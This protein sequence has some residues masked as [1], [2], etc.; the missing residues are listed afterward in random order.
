MQTGGKAIMTFVLVLFATGIFLALESFKVGHVRMVFCDIGQGDGFFITSSKGH[1]IVF[2]GGPGG[3]ITDC[4]SRFLPIWNRKIDVMVPTHPQADH[5]TGQIDVFSKYKVD[6]VVWTGV[7]NETDFFAQ[8]HKDLVDEKSELFNLKRG[9]KIILDDLTFEILWP[10]S[11]QI[12]AWQADKT[13][14]LNDTSYVVRMTKGNVCAYLTGDAPKTILPFVMDKPCDLLKVA[15][16]GSKTGTDSFVLDRAGA[17][18]AV[19]QVGK[20]NRF[21]HPNREVLDVLGEKHMQ[22]LRNDQLGN[23]ELDL[24]GKNFAVRTE[25]K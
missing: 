22:I 19:I 8:W 15:H 13:V 1:V 25:N 6:K 2:D 16:H 14:N 4:L 24:D 17:K 12:S 3:K 20:N 21:G 23:I 10:T 18:I 11:E 5:M 7:T 9:D